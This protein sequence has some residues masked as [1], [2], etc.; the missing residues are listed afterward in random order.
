MFP[1][2]R[3]QRGAVLIV[4][5]LLL[6]VITV[7]A[8]GASQS[9]RLEER[10]AGSQ[11]N[12]DLAFQAA[13]AALRSGE[14]W[15][16]EPSRKR[17]PVTCNELRNPPCQVYERNYVRNQ[18]ADTEQ[19][20]QTDEWWAQR[21]QPYATD[22]AQISGAGRAVRDPMFYIEFVEE[23]PDSLAVPLAGPPAA[24]LYYRIV[25]RGLGGTADAIVVLHSTFVRRYQ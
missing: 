14:R 24:R 4:S 11:R 5:L 9:T 20:Y 16:K 7:L 21:A 3:Q 23:V 10:I 8:L 25:S 15:V 18:V 6:L 17:P 13:E 22:G 12:Y 2:F 19:A 1:S